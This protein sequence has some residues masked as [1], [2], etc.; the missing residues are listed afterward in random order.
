MERSHAALRTDL[1][2]VRR[3]ISQDL[4]TAIRETLRLK[5]RKLWYNITPKKAAVATLAPD[6]LNFK[7]R[8]ISRSAWKYCIRTPRIYQ[9]NIVISSMDTVNNRSS[10]M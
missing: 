9:E 7:A 1:Q 4:S 5:K 2:S 8:D 6:N 3:E 10:N